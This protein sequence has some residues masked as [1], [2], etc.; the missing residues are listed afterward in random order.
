[1]VY[2]LGFVVLGLG[3]WV[4]EVFRILGLAF[5]GYFWDGSDMYLDKD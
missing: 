1:M 4:L 5:L 3:F 2:S